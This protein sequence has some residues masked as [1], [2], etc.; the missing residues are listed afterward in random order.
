MRAGEGL[1]GKIPCSGTE[2]WRTG[3]VKRQWAVLRSSGGGA[4][5]TVHEGR[6]RAVSPVGP[7][8]A[9]RL[10]RPH[11]W[12]GVCV[13][14]SWLSG[15]GKADACV[16]AG[17]RARCELRIFCRVRVLSAVLRFHV[18]WGWGVLALGASVGGGNAAAPL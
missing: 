2:G 8:G 9:V 15:C 1:A 7:A 14:A 11:V 3:V 12:L 16:L 5:S 10:N 6:V 13:C 17:P 4:S 18:R